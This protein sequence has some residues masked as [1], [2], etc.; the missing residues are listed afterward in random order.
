ML[1]ESVKLVNSTISKI[2][3]ILKMDCMSKYVDVK[4]TPKVIR[5][6]FGLQFISGVGILHHLCDLNFIL[7]QPKGL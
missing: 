3:Q 5:K 7:S 1:A 6:T 2:C 4:Y